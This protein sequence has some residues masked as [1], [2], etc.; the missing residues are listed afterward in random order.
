[1]AASKLNS[2]NA[3]LE[4]AKCILRDNPDKRYVLA[5][6][7]I[8]DFKLVNQVFGFQKGNEILRCVE[9]I[10]DENSDSCEAYAQLH[11]DQFVFLV[12]KNKFTTSQFKQVASLC[13]GLIES[14]CFCLHIQLGIYEITD[15]DMEILAMCDRANLAIKSIKIDEPLAIAWYTESFMEKRLYSKKIISEFE[16]AIQNKRFLMYLQPQANTKGEIM[17]AEALAR[18]LMEDG[19]ILSPS[20]FISILEE[21]ELIWKL[22]VYMWEEAA[23]LL[24]KWKHDDEKKNLSISV[25]ISPKDLYYIDI[26]KRLVDL[27]HKY[28]ISPNKMNVEI[29]ESSFVKNADLYVEL[30]SRLHK[31]GFAIEIDDFGSGYSS[32]NMLKNIHADILKL[33][34]AFLQSGDNL[35]RSQI[36]IDSIIEMAKRLDMQVISEGVETQEQAVF[37]KTNG[38]DFFQGFYFSRPVSIDKFDTVLK[39]YNLERTNPDKRPRSYRDLVKEAV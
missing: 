38:C 8:R 6:T 21:S 7:N 10:L 23:R 4:R 24:S 2:M 13:T 9:Q 5:R 31:H 26:E 1:M 22:D 39:A 14:P 36:I 37:L 16:S 32:L 35:I 17:S 29:T 20:H 28:E 25:N 18:W 12:E 19:T 27:V 11:I 15:P 33:D 34:M 3:F 30:I